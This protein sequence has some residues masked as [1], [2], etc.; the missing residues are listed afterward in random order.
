MSGATL[1]SYIWG[2]VIP[3]VELTCWHSSTRGILPK[4]QELHLGHRGREER[5]WFG[6]D[7]CGEKEVSGK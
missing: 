4:C 2:V 5:A 1:G 3:Q 6:E 7:V